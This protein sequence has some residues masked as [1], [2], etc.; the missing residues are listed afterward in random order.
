MIGSLKKAFKNAKDNMQD[1]LKVVTFTSAFIAIFAYVLNWFISYRGS[2]VTLIIGM[3]NAF[4]LMSHFPMF[5]L[6]IPQ[7]CYTFYRAIFEVCEF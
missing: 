6:I 4:E 2:I 3:V 5:R 1:S 7:N